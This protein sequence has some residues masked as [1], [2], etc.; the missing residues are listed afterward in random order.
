MNNPVNI[1]S[2]FGGHECGR[3]ALDEL[4][5]KVNSYLS[6]E[7]NPFAV[8]VVSENYPDVVH[9]GDITKWKEWDVDFGSIDL[10]IGGSPC[11]DVSFAGSGKGLIEGTRSSLLY[12]FIEIM[13]HIKS[14]N[15][16]LKVML[17]NVTMSKSN[18]REFTRVMECEPILLKSE[19][20]AP[21][22]R[23]R[24]YWSNLEIEPLV[25]VDIDFGDIREWGV[26]KDRGMYYSEAAFNWLSNHAKR[27]G[28]D[29]KV[30]TNSG[31]FQMLE[32]TMHKKYSSQRF[33]G[34][35]DVHGIRYPTVVE[36]CRMHGVKDDYFKSVSDTQAY[37]MLGN[38]W[39][40]R[41][42]KHI[43]KGMLND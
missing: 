8:K 34:V 20:I 2:L 15:P 4:G 9:L 42:V 38:G 30:Y 1:L 11:Q 41:T 37:Q 23:N 35:L 28:K 12:C 31:K 29:F 36:C 43:L 3:I 6:S 33:F 10:L 25:K 7:I 21:V 40:V 27:K 17:E 13:N 14:L 22:V 32:A 26:D 16:K 5:V 24:L 18:E 39:E 19:L